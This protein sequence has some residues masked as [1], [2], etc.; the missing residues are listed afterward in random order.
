[1]FFKRLFVMFLEFSEIWFS[2]FLVTNP[3]LERITPTLE[4]GIKFWESCSP[5]FEGSGFSGRIS[6][7]ISS[8]NLGVSEGENQS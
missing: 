1:M 3:P 7:L 5:T 2:E 4:S 6:K 8:G